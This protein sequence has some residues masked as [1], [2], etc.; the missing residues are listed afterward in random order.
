V[1]RRPVSDRQRAVRGHATSR[2]CAYARVFP[3]GS[4]YPYNF[5]TA[6]GYT[7][8]KDLNGLDFAG[9]VQK[10]GLGMS[11]NEVGDKTAKARDLVRGELL[12]L[13]DYIQAPPQK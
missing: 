4:D 11:P 8:F 7:R 1:H 6:S 9:V 2:D 10:A 12:V 3:G 5:A 13:V